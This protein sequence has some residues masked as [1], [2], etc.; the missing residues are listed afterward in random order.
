MPSTEMRKSPDADDLMI[1]M[2]S[3]FSMKLRPITQE[4]FNSQ[5]L[6]D[7]WGT[8]KGEQP[9]VLKC[10]QHEFNNLSQEWSEDRGNGISRHDK[11]SEMGLP[12]HFKK[13]YIFH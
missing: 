9:E 13:A 3:Q 10:S 2:C 1:K 6:A 11:W 4:Y 8:L 5:I 12:E 7:T